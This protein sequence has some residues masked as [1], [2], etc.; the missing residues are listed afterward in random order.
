MARPFPLTLTPQYVFIVEYKF[1]TVFVSRFAAIENIMQ[2]VHPFLLF[3]VALDNSN[4]TRLRDCENAF[5]YV[6]TFLRGAYTRGRLSV[7]R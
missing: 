2:S 3:L 6:Y 5:D 4:R 7:S 1:A